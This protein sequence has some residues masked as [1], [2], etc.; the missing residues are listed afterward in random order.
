MN[1]AILL[2]KCLE[3][4]NVLSNGLIKC[5]YNYITFKIVPVRKILFARQREAAKS[6]LSH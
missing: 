3:R 4:T 1:F 2:E 5:T 6:Y